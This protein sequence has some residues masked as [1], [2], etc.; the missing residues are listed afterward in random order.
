MDLAKDTSQ[1]EA[2]ARSLDS[3]AKPIVSASFDSIVRIFLRIR[4]AKSSRV[5]ERHRTMLDAR[6][7]PDPCLPVQASG[8]SSTP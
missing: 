4:R 8:A 3:K 1:I 7:Q 2:K 5:E 6:R